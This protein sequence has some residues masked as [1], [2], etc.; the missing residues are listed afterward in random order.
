MQER[1]Q[2]IIARA[3]IASRRRAEDLIR[4]GQ[5]T[6]NGKIVTELG[7]RA[8]AGRDHIKVGGRLLRGAPEAV[9]ILLHKPSGCVSALSDPDGR[10]TVRPFIR[11]VAE[12]VFPVGVLDYHAQGLLLLTNDGALANR[13]MQETYRLA[14]TYWLKVKGRL[15][16]AELEQLQRDTQ[17][18]LRLAREGGNAWYEV[19]IGGRPGRAPGQTLDELRSAL[20]AS[21]H[22]VEKQRRVAFGPLELGDLQ[23]GQFRE[24]KKGEAQELLQAAGVA[25]GGPAQM[26]DRVARPAASIRRK[27]EKTSRRSAADSRSG[28]YAGGTRGRGR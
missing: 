25:T 12:R 18:R 24:L 15:G 20:V 1:L 10:P 13:V 16:A 7:T 21:G 6:V 17:F 9:Y 22:P 26:R 19:R 3:G 11:T 27:P 2:K 23:P 5:V 28:R 8:D 4:A 14:Q